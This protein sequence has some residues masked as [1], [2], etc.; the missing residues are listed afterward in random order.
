MGSGTFA[1]N[2]HAVTAFFGAPSGISERFV[3]ELIRK[4]ESGE[5]ERREPE[6]PL[7][8]QDQPRR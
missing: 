7:A 5:V 2:F 3:P 1:D 4:L 6:A 8:S